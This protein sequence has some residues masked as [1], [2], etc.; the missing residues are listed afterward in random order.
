MCQGPGRARTSST[1]EQRGSA[2]ACG[3]N[4]EGRF[5]ETTR[6]HAHTAGGCNQ[7]SS[8]LQAAASA[9]ARPVRAERDTELGSGG[10]CRMGRGPGCGGTL[11]GMGRRKQWRGAPRCSIPSLSP[12]R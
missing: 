1:M 7:A 11:G 6:L 2:R 5:A 10:K 3:P 4:P 8:P 9:T 12:E